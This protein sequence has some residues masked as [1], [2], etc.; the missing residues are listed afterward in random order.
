MNIAI[1]N[2]IPLVHARIQRYALEYEFAG[3]TWLEQHIES[4]TEVEYHTHKIA[5]SYSA[6]NIYASIIMSLQAWHS[7]LVDASIHSSS[8]SSST[9]P[10]FPC[11]VPLNYGI[12][13]WNIAILKYL[14]DPWPLHFCTLELCSFDPLHPWVCILHIWVWIWYFCHVWIAIGGQLEQKLMY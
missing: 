3:I 8:R 13:W 10:T 2:C 4:T 6:F 7:S 1:C 12:D 11:R 5:Q 9:S 14:Q